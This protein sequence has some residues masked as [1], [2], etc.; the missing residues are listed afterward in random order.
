MRFNIFK[1]AFSLTE[2]LIVLVVVAVL[3]SAMLP[4]MSKRRNSTTTSSEPVWQFVNSETKDAFYDKGVPAWTTT[5]YFGSN[6]LNMN[7]GDKQPLAKMSIKAV[8]TLLNTSGSVK[9]QDM[10]QFRYGVGNGVLTGAFLMDN[11]ANAFMTNRLQGAET[12]NYNH[13]TASCRSGANDSNTVWGQGAFTRVKQV[14]ENTVFGANVMVGSKDSIDNN[15]SGNVA[16]GVGANRYGAAQ[17]SVLIGANAGASAD[18]DSISNTVA[19]GDSSL[20][21]QG[22]STFPAS[23]STNGVFAGY[24]VGSVGAYGPGNTILG[25]MYYGNG[26][27]QYNTFIGKAYEHGNT[28]AQYMTAIGYN[29]CDSFVNPQNQEQYSKPVKS[30]CIGYYSAANYG[31]NSA[32]ASSNWERDGQEHIF[33]GGPPA[34]GES[35][36]GGRAVLEVHNIDTSNQ[37]SDWKTKSAYPRISPTVV[38]NSNLVVRGNT[39]WAS[40]ASSQLGYL[41]SHGNLYIQYDQTEGGDDWCCRSK[42]LGRKKW[43]NPK[44]KSLLGTVLGVVILA[45]GVVAC[46]F[47][48]GMA[49]PVLGGMVTSGAG[50]SVV[51][52]DLVTAGSKG[53]RQKDPKSHSVVAIPVGK[54]NYCADKETNYMSNSTNCL[55]LKLSDG[56]LKEN[57]SE[58]SDAIEK[59]LMIMPYNYTYKAD[60]TAKPQ[61][62]VIAQD[63]QTYFP[64]SV[65][66]DKDSYLSIRWDEMF[67]ATVNSVKSLDKIVQNLTNDT[68]SLDKDTNVIANEQKSVQKRIDA[69]NKRLNKLEK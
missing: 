32:T 4:I 38:F 18:E 12:S 66:E 26:D 20:G 64:N 3:F 57:I 15:K 33:I 14:T 16:V 35:T 28:N 13:I 68:D 29:A 17:N 53:V 60:K 63:L 46:V 22:S 19:L 55:D 25:S 62:G 59:L 27:A 34:N 52:Y 31:S 45:A 10:I 7:T 30:T 58:N 36:V 54:N 67:F 47:S 11:C 23:H 42:G 65:S 61:V 2:L 44:C 6:A 5:A 49:L 24:Y 69:I 1:R 41:V 21:I 9:P 51:T 40:T 50:V 43:H 8:G 56:R 39:Y 37:S 48:G